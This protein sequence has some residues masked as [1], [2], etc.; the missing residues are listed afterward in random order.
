M[1]IV[2]VDP[3]VLEASEVIVGYEEGGKRLDQI[4]HAHDEQFSTPVLDYRVDSINVRKRIAQDVR[5]IPALS[6]RCCTH[7]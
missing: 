6:D 1:A 7:L 2:E 3:D 5:G 4:N